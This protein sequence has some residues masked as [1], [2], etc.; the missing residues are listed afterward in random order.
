VNHPVATN[1]DSR[2]RELAQRK[3]WRIL[4]LFTEQA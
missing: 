4:D 3:G 1:P 2:L